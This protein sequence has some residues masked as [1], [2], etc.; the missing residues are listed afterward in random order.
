MM[1]NEMET[2]LA[3]LRADH[4]T[5]LDDADHHD[6]LRLWLRL[7]TCTTMIERGIR[8]RLR[9]RFGMAL[10]RFDLLAQLDRAP[11]G[12]RMGELSRRLMVTGGNVTGLVAQLVAEGLVERS[13]APGDRRAC[14]ARLTARG[15]DAFRDMAAEHERWIV[16]LMSG[17]AAGDR[18][19]LHALLGALKSSVRVH[20]PGEAPDAIARLASTAS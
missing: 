6:A 10:A 14:V 20:E 2:M 17:V 16:E 3:P 5:R 9:D 12:L 1:G 7:L 18:A 13:A 11:S 8:R 19:R 4:E 15:R